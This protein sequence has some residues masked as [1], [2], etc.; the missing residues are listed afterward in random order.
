MNNQVIALMTELEY[1]DI[2]GIVAA[3]WQA[4]QSYD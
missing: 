1:T 4:G 3:M 2:L